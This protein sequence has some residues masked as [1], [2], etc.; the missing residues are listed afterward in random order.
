VGLVQGGFAKQKRREI[1]DTTLTRMDVIVTASREQ[2]IQDQQGDLWDPVQDDIISMDQILELGDVLT[3]KVTG[4]TR[5]NQ[6]TLFKNN[7]GQGIADVAIGARVY[8]RARERGLGLELPGGVWGGTA[9]TG[10]RA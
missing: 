9:V 2:V 10:A 6:L 5:A 3:G 1:D 8:A 7:A 4:R